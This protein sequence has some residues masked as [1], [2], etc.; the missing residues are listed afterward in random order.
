[1]S[2]SLTPETERAIQ[3]HLETGHYLSAD[4]AIQEPLRMLEEHDLTQG[5]QQLEELRQKIAIGIEK[6]AQGKTTDGETV[7]D[8]LRSKIQREYPSQA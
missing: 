8:N 4:A 7:F 1:M 6:I 2:L 3:Q 5:K